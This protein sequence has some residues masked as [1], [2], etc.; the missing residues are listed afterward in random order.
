VDASAVAAFQRWIFQPGRKNG[1][2]IALEVVVEIPF[3][4]QSLF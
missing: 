1:A 2:P 4:L 3:R